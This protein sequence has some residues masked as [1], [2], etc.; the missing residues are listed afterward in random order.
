VELTAKQLADRIGLE[1]QGKPEVVLSRIND[2][3]KAGEGDLSFLASANFRPYLQQTR[4][5]AVI[6]KREDLAFC[7]AGVTALIS[8]NPYLSYARAAQILHPP[9]RHPAGIH[10]RAEVHETASID[11]T[12]HVAANSFIGAGAVLA[13]GVSIGAGC[14]IEEGVS[15]GADTVLEPHVTL[16]SQVVVGARCLIHPGAVIGADG[17]GFANEQGSW[18]KI[19]QIGRVL[20]GDDVEIGANTTIDR[21]AIGDTVIADGVKLD[22]LIQVAHNVEIGQHTA[23]A[24]CTGIAGSTTIGERCAIG[25]GVG[26]VGHLQIADDVV[27]T[28][29]TFVAQSI[30]DRGTYSSGVPM[31]PVSKWRRNYLRFRQLDEI[32]RRIKKLEKTIFITDDKEP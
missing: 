25:G 21:G 30:T 14:I 12:V 10:P 32:A 17:F 5:A 26:I 28:G 19:P 7:P 13:R 27:I 31:E 15:I 16:M 4:A 3:K 29:Q 24:G 9:R 8:Q 1:L 6:L 22:N 11:A 23:I 2:L 20:I 18:I